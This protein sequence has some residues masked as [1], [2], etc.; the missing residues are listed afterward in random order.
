MI[1]FIHRLLHPHCVECI[2]EAKEKFEELTYCNTCESLKN[3]NVFLRQQIKDLQDHILHPSIPIESNI[4]IDELKP[5]Q[6]LRKPFSVIRNELEQ[7][8]RQ[9]AKQI[10]E[11]LLKNAAAK[12]D[13][14]PIVDS[15]GKVDINLVNKELEQMN[16]EI[17]QHG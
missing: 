6:P 9:K 7:A 15:E 12:V 14:N 17:K 5:I 2:I 4:N 16:Q 10:D 3:E 8:D 1:N 11:Q 13:P